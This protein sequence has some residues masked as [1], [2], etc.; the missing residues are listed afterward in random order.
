MNYKLLICL[1]V[2]SAGLQG[3]I[4]N[5][6][7]NAALNKNDQVLADY[8]YF[9]YEL[10]K[11]KDAEFTKAAKLNAAKYKN[12]F[13]VELKDAKA[14]SFGGGFAWQEDSSKKGDAFVKFE[15]LF[16]DSGKD[17]AGYV[18]MDALIKAD[19]TKAKT[20]LQKAEQAVKA[21]IANT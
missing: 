1:F 12:A 2:C 3:G 11:D 15:N 19:K 7:F 9:K 20:A 21:A 10:D 18:A 8:V 14:P 13:K 4:G 5:D 6:I 17:N 16:A